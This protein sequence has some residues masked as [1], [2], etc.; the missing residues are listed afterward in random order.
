MDVLECIR[1]R[2]SIR[3][4]LTKPVEFDK[5]LVI[6]E[7][8]HNAPSAGNLQNWRFIILTDKE[9][10][11]KLPQHCLNQDFIAAPVVIIV[12]SENED[13]EKHYGIRG[14]RLYAVQNCAAAIE[15]MLL[16]AHAIHLGACWIGAFDEEKIGEIC[17]IPKHARPQ[18]L[19]TIGYPAED[20]PTKRL[21]KFEDVV[22]FNTYNNKIKDIHLETRNYSD[23]IEKRT[24]E[25]Q[26]IVSRGKK[27][28]N[29][30]W[31]VYV[32]K[33]LKKK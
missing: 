30:Y 20:P 4:Y 10:I 11:Q 28:I 33:G 31:N 12:C 22:H 5:I 29:D 24:K 27:K 3:K 17:Q 18:A 8:G 7:A 21:R 19:L 14:S 25:V 16:A 32:P 23:E 6:C 26:G 2:R 15:N 13:M 1:T 9:I